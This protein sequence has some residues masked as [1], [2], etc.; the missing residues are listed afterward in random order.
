MV[1]RTRLLVIAS[2]VIAVAVGPAAM[3]SA[4]GSGGDDATASA[5]V[6]KKKFKKLKKQVAALQQQLDQFE[7]TP[8]PR[9]PQGSRRR[10]APRPRARGTAPATRWLPPARSA[11][12]GTR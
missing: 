1:K 4:P 7:A 9:G 8:G 3:A 2:V 5:G 11:S 6:S 12:T 10:P